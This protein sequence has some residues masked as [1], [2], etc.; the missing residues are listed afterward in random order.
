MPRLQLASHVPSGVIASA[1][2]D[3]AGLGKQ[4]RSLRVAKSQIRTAPASPAVASHVPSGPIAT[5]VGRRMMP[6]SRARCCPDA[7]SQIRIG[8]S[9]SA[10]LAIHVPSLA[11]ATAVTG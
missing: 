5:D 9:A 11:I 2:A 1:V 4:I 8:C 3:S 7:V 10:T 6:G